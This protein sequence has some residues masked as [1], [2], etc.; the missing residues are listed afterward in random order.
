MD[1]L[2]SV[3]V[4]DFPALG[5]TRVEDIVMY[6]ACDIKMSYTLASAGVEILHLASLPLSNHRAML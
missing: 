4:P 6:A 2:L 5:T 1:S 3:N